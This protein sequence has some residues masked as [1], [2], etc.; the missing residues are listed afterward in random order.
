M[1]RGALAEVS[2]RKL[3]GALDESR[4]K[5]RD[6]IKKRDRMNYFVPPAGEV[7]GANKNKR[8]LVA[9]AGFGRRNSLRPVHG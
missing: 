8:V 3:P 2:R 7:N 9:P 5:S 6:P 4:C 1:L